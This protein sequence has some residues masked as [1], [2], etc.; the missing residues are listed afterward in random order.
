[1]EETAL[2]D[3]KVAAW[4]DAITSL[5]GD[6]EHWQSKAFLTEGRENIK[7]RIGNDQKFTGTDRIYD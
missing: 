2:T 6:S 7:T 1:M 4:A 5:V 3:A